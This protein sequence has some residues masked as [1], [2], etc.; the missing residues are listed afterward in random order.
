MWL[1][2]G[3]AGEAEGDSKVLA[4]RLARALFLGIGI[5]P[6]VPVRARWLSI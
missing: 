2:F 5:A 3:T 1:G 4:R 6:T